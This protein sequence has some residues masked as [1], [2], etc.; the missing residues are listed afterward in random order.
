MTEFAMAGSDM[1]CDRQIDTDILT[2]AWEMESSFY[3]LLQR[4]ALFMRFAKNTG[5]NLDDCEN[6][7]G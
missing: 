5:I 2:H 7:L 6:L 3:I 4:E 1:K